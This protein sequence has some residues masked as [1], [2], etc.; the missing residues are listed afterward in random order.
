MSTHN[1]LCKKLM[2]VV[3]IIE[4]GTVN[5]L[6]HADGKV[7]DSVNRSSESENEYKICEE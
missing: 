2:Q 3:S 5:L 4:I 7:N 1:L 6:L